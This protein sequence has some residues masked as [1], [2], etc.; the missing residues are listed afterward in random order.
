MFYCS[1][2]SIQ[3]K[4]MSAIRTTKQIEAILVGNQMETCLHN[5]VKLWPFVHKVSIQFHSN[6]TYKLALFLT[7]IQSML[8]N[9]AHQLLWFCNNNG[10]AHE[11]KLV[12]LQC[13]LQ[14]LDVFLSSIPSNWSYICWLEDIYS[15]VVFLLGLENDTI[16][17]WD[18]CHILSPFLCGA[19]FYPMH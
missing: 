1:I 8:H 17:F 2:L 4:H 14:H 12:S 18:C 16:L 10:T 13:H 9:C 19:R 6:V 15:P 11:S 5:G 3:I 7:C